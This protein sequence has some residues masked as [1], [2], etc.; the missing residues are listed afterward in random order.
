ML[1]NKQVVVQDLL[2][3][4]TPHLFPEN[5]PLIRTV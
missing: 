2:P 5:P 3:M 1:W 4:I